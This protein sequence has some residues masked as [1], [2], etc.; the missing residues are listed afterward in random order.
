ME[1]RTEAHGCTISLQALLAGLPQEADRDM[2]PEN[3]SFSHAVHDEK[4]VASIIP[5]LLADM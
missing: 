1:F 3:H 5:V 2:A 4:M